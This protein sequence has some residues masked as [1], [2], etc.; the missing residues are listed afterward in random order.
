MFLVEE[1]SCGMTQ[2]LTT[3]RPDRMTKNMMLYGSQEFHD[4]GAILLAELVELRRSEVSLTVF[5][6]ML[7]SK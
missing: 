7:Q 1:K 3:P 4:A 5:A 2:G 6:S